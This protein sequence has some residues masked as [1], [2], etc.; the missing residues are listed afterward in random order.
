MRLSK[1]SNEY[2]I[3]LNPIRIESY[4]NSKFEPTNKTCG[5]QIQIQIEKKN[6]YFFVIE[7]ETIY[8][9]IEA[10]DLN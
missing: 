2:Q 4:K 3:D 8:N 1:E 7:I 5:M 10:Y 9:Q 6:I